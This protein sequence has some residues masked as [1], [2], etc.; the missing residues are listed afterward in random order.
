[1]F[2]H[3]PWDEG[4]RNW[5]K[6]SLTKCNRNSLRLQHVGG[7]SHRTKISRQTSGYLLGKR[8]CCI[9]VLQWLLV[10]QAVI[11]IIK[12]KSNNATKTNPLDIRHRSTYKFPVRFLMFLPTLRLHQ[13]RPY[14][15]AEMA[16]WN[17]QIRSLSGYRCLGQEWVC[18]ASSLT[19]NQKPN[20]SLSHPSQKVGG[21]RKWDRVAS[22]NSEHRK[23]RLG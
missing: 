14:V 12:L 10:Q 2:D 4:G 11:Y 21:S 9:A 17:H 19:H 20:G 1:M 7:E 16:P 6:T 3:T 15:P 8:V 13:P 18:K 22:A 5:C 23:E